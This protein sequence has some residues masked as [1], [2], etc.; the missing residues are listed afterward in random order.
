M[1]KR[2]TRFEQVPIEVAEN[3]FRHQT[4]RPKSIASGTLLLRNPVPVRAGLRCLL[5]RRP[6]SLVPERLNRR[7]S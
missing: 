7:S 6:Y 1:Q 5:C 4:G 3:A 2:K